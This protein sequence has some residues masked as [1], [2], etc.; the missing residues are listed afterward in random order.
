MVLSATRA[1]A[2]CVEASNVAKFAAE[3]RRGLEKKSLE[4]RSAH[5]RAEKLRNTFFE[6][7]DVCQK[8]VVPD[9]RSQQVKYEAIYEGITARH[10]RD[11][12]ALNATFAD[13][14]ANGA[15]DEHGGFVPR[16]YAQ[17]GED[18][19]SLHYLKRV[20]TD[21]AHASKL[22]L[23]PAVERLRD[24]VLGDLRLLPDE[25]SVDVGPTKHLDRAVEKAAEDYDRDYSRLI[26][27]SRASIVCGRPAGADGAVSQRES[28]PILVQVIRAIARRHSTHEMRVLRFKNRFGVRCDPPGGYRDIQLIVKFRGLKHLCELQVIRFAARRALR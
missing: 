19:T 12:D 16:Q 28:F 10:V 9:I 26:D 20:L 15:A 2:M 13:L 1:H 25:L 6:L 8:A 14:R 23:G 5:R 7:R 3:R 27:L 24:E 17:P 22:M 4:H 21:S 18:A 11:L